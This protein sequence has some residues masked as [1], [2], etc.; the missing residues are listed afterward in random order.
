MSRHG[1][2]DIGCG[3]GNTMDATFR[4]CTPHESYYYLS[5]NHDL[6]AR[7]AQNNNTNSDTMRFLC[8]CTEEVTDAWTEDANTY[9]A[10]A[11]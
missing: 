3:A 1:N 4:S 8:T 5:I 10:S 11:V 2:I 6:K 9:S 7:E